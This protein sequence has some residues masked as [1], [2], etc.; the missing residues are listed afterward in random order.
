MC[1]HGMDDPMFC[2]DCRKETSVVSQY[3]YDGIMAHLIH[4]PDK[5]WWELP[6]ACLKGHNE[7]VTLY[8]SSR[9]A[10]HEYVYSNLERHG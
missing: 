10:A 5:G 1:N 2:N 7:D 3:A 9:Y 4:N 8:F 6:G